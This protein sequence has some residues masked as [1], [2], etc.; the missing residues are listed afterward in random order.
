MSSTTSWKTSLI[1]S[2]SFSEILLL[3]GRSTPLTEE[4]QEDEDEVTRRKDLEEDIDIDVVAPHTDYPHRPDPLLSIPPN[5]AD[6]EREV[7]EKAVKAMTDVANWVQ[8]REGDGDTWEAFFIS[9]DMLAQLDEV[10]E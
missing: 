2:V 3:R 5:L 4:P 1:S 7:V 9:V 8:D 6:E 10:D